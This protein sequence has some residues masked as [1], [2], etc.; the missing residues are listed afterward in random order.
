M[1]RRAASA[2]PEKDSYAEKVR[3]ELHQVHKDLDK[4]IEKAKASETDVR[5]KLVEQGDVVKKKR[6]EMELKLAELADASEERWHD[7]RDEVEHVWRAFRHS[8]NYFKS[9]F[10]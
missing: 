6:E 3:V 7:V 9:H 4:L 1:T 5:A 10:K 2:D 8:V